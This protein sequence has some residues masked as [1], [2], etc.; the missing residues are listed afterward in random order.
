MG[1]QVQHA[2]GCS[3]QQAADHQQHAYLYELG[4]RVRRVR[5]FRA[6]SHH[7]LVLNKVI[8]NNAVDVTAAFKQCGIYGWTNDQGAVTTMVVLQA[9]TPGAYADNDLL[10]IGTA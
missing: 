8:Y 7:Y 5:H 1:R 10:K 6:S 4:Y 9:D 3:S 2:H